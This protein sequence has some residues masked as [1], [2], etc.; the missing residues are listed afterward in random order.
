MSKLRI[1]VGLPGSGKT[2][3]AEAN[4]MGRLFDDPANNENAMA[5]M[6]AAIKARE[7]VTITDVFFVEP[8]IR[9]AGL[10]AISSWVTTPIDTELIF[11][12]NNPDACVAN[13]VRRN[14]GR[15]VS[16]GYVHELAAG[17]FIPDGA[18]VIPVWTPQEN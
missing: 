14:D 3:Y 6:K 17:Y 16:D 13:I 18:T 11:F 7:D 15:L 9:M 10:I 4:P 5:E 2:H 8:M 1:I 12:E